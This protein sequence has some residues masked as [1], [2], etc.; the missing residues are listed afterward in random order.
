MLTK[1][2]R[3][4]LAEQERK[5]KQQEK[6]HRQTKRWQKSMRK[7]ARKAM[8]KS[9]SG[10]QIFR[11]GRTSSAARRGPVRKSILEVFPIRDI[12]NGYFVTVDNRIIDLF[13]IQGR[14]YYDSSDEE[15]EAMVYSFARFLRMY[16]ADMKFISMN[17]PTSTKVQQTFLTEK[18]RQP[19]LQQ[20]SELLQEELEKLRELEQSTTERESFLMI[21]A[22][23][24]NQYQSLCKL[25]WQLNCVRILPL[26]R[27]KKENII[28]QL[29]N[30]NKQI[31]TQKGD[32]LP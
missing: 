11:F 18:L 31:V 15:I 29:N 4:L 5:Y 32:F 14:S 12:C 24:E 10:G 20:Y 17:Y 19:Q 9:T 27:Q 8:K 1:E 6:L 23:N 30:M 13:Q 3:R 2:E 7:E 16:S 21:F 26:S 28:F 22:D 25:L